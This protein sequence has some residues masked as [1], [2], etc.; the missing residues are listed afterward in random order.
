MRRVEP[1]VSDIVERA[2]LQF[3]HEVNAA[4]LTTNSKVTYIAHAARF[5]RWMRGEFEV[6]VRTKRR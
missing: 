5:I 2:F 3:E 1:R 4:P 6:G